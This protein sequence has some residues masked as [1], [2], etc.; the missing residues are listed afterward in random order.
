MK[1]ICLTSLVSAVQ[2]MNS[3]ASGMCMLTITDMA[4]KYTL[5]V[6]DITAVTMA[7]IHSGAVGKP[8]LLLLCTNRCAVSVLAGRSCRW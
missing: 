6:M 5:T 1:H 7:H 8:T 4:I 2:T 3:M